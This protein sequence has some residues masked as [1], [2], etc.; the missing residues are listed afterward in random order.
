M[1]YCRV[2]CVFD[3][4][5]SSTALWNIL[6][7]QLIERDKKFYLKHKDADY[8]AGVTDRWPQHYP[9]MAQC[10][11]WIFPLLCHTA[12]A[13]NLLCHTAMAQNLLCHT[14]GSKQWIKRG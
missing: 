9:H 13:Q 1:L 2:P 11:S 3:L 12:M 6:I 10:I 8:D 7:D 14:N 4:F 5:I